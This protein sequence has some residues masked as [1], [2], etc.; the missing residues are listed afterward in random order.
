M[1]QKYICKLYRDAV[2]VQVALDNGNQADAFFFNYGSFVT[3]GM[4]EEDEI[5]WLQSIEPYQHKPIDNL[6]SELITYSIGEEIEIEND[7]LTIPDLETLTLIAVSHALAQSVKLGSFE[8]R[9]QKTYNA[10]RHIPEELA[11]KGR[12]SLSRR[13]IRKM[14][15]SLFIERNSINLHFEVLDTPEFFWE[16]PELESIYTT[17]SKEMDI[18]TRVEVLNQRLDVVRELFEMLGN[19]L[20]HQH[21]NRLEMTIIILIVIEVFLTFQKD[22][23]HWF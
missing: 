8:D 19:E 4:T 1:K 12:V 9:I 13:Q 6:E 2:H 3:W 23:L 20:N 14:M 11:K 17:I 7:E 22:I 5:F 10:T 15:G 21:S 16:H 18:S